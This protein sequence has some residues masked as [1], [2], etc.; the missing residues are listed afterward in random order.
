M[1][2]GIYAGESFHSVKKDLKEFV[3]FL[4]GNQRATL[5]KDVISI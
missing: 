4:D 3:K 2:K 5:M 1:K